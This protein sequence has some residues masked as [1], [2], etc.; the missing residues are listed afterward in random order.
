ME[1]QLLNENHAEAYWE[2]RLEMLKQSPSS[3]GS[4]YEEALARPNPIEVTAGRLIQK[5]SHTFGCFVGEK[6][7]G[8]A[9]LVR[10]SALKMRHKASIFAMYVSPVYR[11]NGYA[12]RLIEACISHAKAVEGIEQVMLTVVSTNETAKGLYLSC[13]FKPYGTEKRALKYKNEYFD[14]DL[15][16]LFL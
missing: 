8:T 1:I 4:S 5:D 3:F 2:L 13:G 10:E 9:T 15:M 12:R 6:L 16:V 7:V 14:E 11:G